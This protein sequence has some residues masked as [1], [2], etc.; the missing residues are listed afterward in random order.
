MGLPSY[1]RKKYKELRASKQVFGAMVDQ[2][3][4]SYEQLVDLGM[5]PDM[6][7][8]HIQFI[9][10]FITLN[11]GTTIDRT[12]LIRIRDNALRNVDD[13]S[14]KKKIINHYNNIWFAGI[15]KWYV[16]HTYKW[17]QQKR[18]K[19]FNEYITSTFN[20][21]E[22]KAGSLPRGPY[23]R[24]ETSWPYAVVRK[25]RKWHLCFKLVRI[26]SYYLDR[27]KE[28]TEIKRNRLWDMV[29][30]GQAWENIESSGRFY[31]GGLRQ[32]IL[33]RDG[34]KCVLCGRTTK[35]HGVSLEIDH[36]LP[37]SLGGKT[38]YKNGRT[39]CAECNTSTYLIKDHPCTPV[40]K[41]ALHITGK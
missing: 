26:N 30:T 15:S 8:Q 16:A 19:H 7:N 36:I 38:S 3:L 11:G 24:V 1:L 10:S 32:A 28:L 4:T 40:E 13:E 6:V 33:K 5:L 18:D 37:Y 12:G 17:N 29:H 34:Y 31:S 14:I 23:S 20:R 35:E 22:D 25:G 2:F 21:N 9:C 41:K 39:L 27:A